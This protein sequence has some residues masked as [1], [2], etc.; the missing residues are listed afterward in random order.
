MDAVS[1]LL[2]VPLVAKSAAADNELQRRIANFLLNR[3]LPQS[4]KLRIDAKNG[5]VTL[6]GTHRSYYHKQLCINC[7]QRVAGVVRLIDG[8]HVIPER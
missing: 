1:S 5:V 4:S 3:Q 6:Q 2:D 7:C 8:T